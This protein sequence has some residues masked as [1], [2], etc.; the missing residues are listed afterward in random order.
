MPVL[1]TAQPAK[2]ATPL[3]AA[4][5]LPPVQVRV[6]PPGLVKARVT[7]ALLVVTVLPAASCTAT[8]GCVAIAVPPTPPLGCVVNA[9][10]VAAPGLIVKVLLD[11]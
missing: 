9:S 6:A 3:A 11:G 7:E 8:T 1:F 10:L 2:V 4:L 5:G